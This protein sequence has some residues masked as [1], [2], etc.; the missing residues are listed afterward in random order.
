MPMRLCVYDHAEWGAPL[1]N[2]ADGDW[3]SWAT[4]HRRALAAWEQARRAWFDEFG[5]L[6]GNDDPVHD[7]PFEDADI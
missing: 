4:E 5:H 6:P 2:P 1:D 3:T 7:E